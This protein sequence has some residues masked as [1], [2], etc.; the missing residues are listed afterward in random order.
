MMPSVRLDRHPPLQPGWIDAPHRR[1]AL[2]DL[3]LESGERILDF[4]ASYV[5][6]GP[7]D[8]TL[9]VALGLCAIG[10]SHHR[11]DFLIGPG[12]ALDPTRMRIVIVDAIGNGLTT[13]PSNS[14]RQPRSAFPRFTI[15]DMVRSQ[16]MLLDVLG[17]ERC[18]V[19]IGASMGG[20]QALQWGA[21]HPSDMDRIVALTPLARTPPW[22]V[23]FNH[24]ARQ[25]L[26]GHD[27]RAAAGDATA[28]SGWVTLMQLLAMR[29][30]EQVDAELET[31]DRVP[32]WLAQ[33][34]A[35]WAAQRVDPLDWIYQSWAYDAHDVGTTPGFGGDTAAALAAIRAKTLIVS[36]PGDLYNPAAGAAWAVARIPGCE[37]VTLDSHWGHLAASAAD[38]A[39]AAALH[40]EITRFMSLHA[41]TP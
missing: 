32:G 17:I 4:E 15:R 5:V 41:P 23:A 28:W 16:R 12:A 7:D 25:S 33:R 29:T 35:W 2:G 14:R 1:C 22:S 31:G 21:M 13:S 6:H 37:H 26:E 8:P 30:P 9:P 40:R 19:V 20:M 34:T 11:L 36:V 3:V 39:S 24:A 38:A 27:A 10:S 18:A